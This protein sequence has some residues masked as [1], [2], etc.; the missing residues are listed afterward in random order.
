[1]GPLGIAL[2]WNAALF[3]SLERTP[4]Q[5]QN[6]NTIMELGFEQTGAILSSSPT[7][8]IHSALGVLHSAIRDE[9]PGLNSAGVKAV[10][11]LIAMA[12]PASGAARI[13]ANILQ[14][15]RADDSFFSEASRI[16]GLPYQQIYQWDGRVSKPL[17]GS[18]FNMI[19]PFT[20]THSSTDPVDIRLSNLDIALASPTAQWHSEIIDGE[21]HEINLTDLPHS[22]SKDYEMQDGIKTY[23]VKLNHT[24]YDE[25]N[26]IFRSITFTEQH[27]ELQGRKLDFRQ[28]VEW[29][30]SHK[31]DSAN[32]TKFTLYNP[33]TKRSEPI[34]I[35]GISDLSDEQQIAI[36]R[37]TRTKLHKS[38]TDI[39]KSRNPHVRKSILELMNAQTTHQ[40]STSQNLEERGELQTSLDRINEELEHLNDTLGQSNDR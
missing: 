1:M 9:S 22:D 39:L 15:P 34:A 14:R 16:S 31:Y 12:V 8:N 32:P 37:S 4:L 3:E 23:N 20:V 7:E 40:L 35:H 13:M 17:K 10:R 5:D 27:P 29:M 18:W 36:L 24:A 26:E 38:V 33:N 25:Y 30:L 19:S 11:D 2:S 21:L 6:F 28:T